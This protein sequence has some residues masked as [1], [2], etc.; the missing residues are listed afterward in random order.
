MP[1]RRKSPK[2]LTMIEQK[3]LETSR[4]AAQRTKTASPPI[5]SSREKTTTILEP[6]EYEIKQRKERWRRE[7]IRDQLRQTPNLWDQICNYTFTFFD[8]NGDLT[9]YPVW[10]K[11]GDNGEYR[12]LVKIS[13]NLDRFA[14]YYRKHW[15]YELEIAT[16]GNDLVSQEVCKERLSLL[17]EGKMVIPVNWRGGRFNFYYFNTRGRRYRLRKTTIANAYRLLRKYVIAKTR[18]KSFVRSKLGL[19]VQHYIYNFV[20]HPFGR[21]S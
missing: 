10:N 18:P 19:N 8:K 16:N 21:K 20:S 3:W 17:E 5:S 7:K 15:L 9:T 13:E 14:S 6:N 2:D 12:E 11:I 1:H 4:R